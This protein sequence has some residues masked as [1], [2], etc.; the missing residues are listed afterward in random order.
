MV[1]EADVGAAITILAGEPQVE[2][3][4]PPL[5]VATMDIPD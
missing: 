5:G 3:V 4:Y 2:N 1:V